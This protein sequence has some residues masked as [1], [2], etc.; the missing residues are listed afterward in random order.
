MIT[1][2]KFYADWCGPCKALQPTWDKIKEEFAESVI[3]QDVNIDDNP[4]TR[5]DYNVRSI[6]AFVMIKDRQEIAR[7][8]GGGTF[9]ELED[10]VI[11]S[12]N[13]QS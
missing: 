9:S 2:I 4:Q 7:R 3:F 10:W 6:P 13:L 11:E 8:Q 5:A 1:I 12:G